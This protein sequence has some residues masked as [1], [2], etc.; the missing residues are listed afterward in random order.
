MMRIRQTFNAWA[1]VAG[2]L[3]AF[4]PRTAHAAPV[5]A[6]SSCLGATLTALNAAKT[7]AESLAVGVKA[8]PSLA[9]G[10]ACAKY[11][12]GYT[13]GIASTPAEDEWQG[14]QRATQL[15]DEAAREY[16]NEPRLY[17]ALGLLAYNRQA[18]TDA[19]RI[20]DR[21][22]GHKNDG[23][24]PLTPHEIAVVFYNRGLMHQDLWRDWRSFGHLLNTVGGQ[25]QCAKFQE[26]SHATFSSNSD[27]YG[28]LVGFNQVCPTQFDSVMAGFFV[29]DSKL[30]QEEFLQLEAA[31]DSAATADT[32]FAEPLLALMSEYVYMGAWEKADPVTA[33]LRRRAPDDYRS[34]ALSALVQHET[35]RDSLAN[36][37]FGQ[38]LVRMSDTTLAVYDDI[39][40]LLEPDQVA[41]F[42]QADVTTRAKAIGAFWNALDPLYIT[43]FNERKLEHYARVTTAEIAFGSLALHEHGWNSFAGKIWIRYGRPVN[44][45]ELSKA[46]GRVAFWNYGGDADITF[47]RGITRTSY[48]GTDD[49][50]KYA[51][52]LAVVRPQGYRTSNFIDSVEALDHQIVRFRGPDGR[53]QLL[54]Y[55]AVPDHYSDQAKAALL[56]LDAQFQ[57]AAEWRGARP[58]IGGIK[59]LFTGMRQGMYSL[60][61]ELWDAGPRRLGRAR[62]TVSFRPDTAGGPLALSDLLLAA[63][64]EAG[65]AAATPAGVGRDGLNIEP[66]Y[67]LSLV[68][69]HPLSVY[70]EIYGLKASADG[71]ARYE[72]TVQV[73]DNARRPMLARMLGVGG[74]REAASKIQ[75]NGTHV[76]TNGRV[77]EWL[78]LS[79]DLKPGSYRVVVTVVDK[80]GGA[81]KTVER[82]L[83]VK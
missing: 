71:R 66:L 62:D 25:L 47:E 40:L 60:T 10:S 67:G 80:D 72:V 59:R 28:W 27:D 49:A 8:E 24:L 39:A 26:Q 75:Y 58:P 57:A 3:T 56:L 82:G 77:A 48:R 46:S 14:R 61:V 31:F 33:A 43:P 44:M 69:N 29:P 70:W 6:D 53:P 64:I 74:G 34:W 38:A 50:I 17:L 37:Q 73:Q 2:A 15:L 12:V 1:L 36:L 51:N 20:L 21:A 83:I 54:V 41:W 45:R 13:I 79:S 5:P 30:K 35:R 68:Q 19:F 78:S 23:P 63:S 76:V 65:P 55:A 16:G 52:D 32:T 22:I 4:A 9:T 81:T 7:R 18:R 11:V 42:N